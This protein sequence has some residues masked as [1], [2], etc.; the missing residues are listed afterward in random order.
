MWESDLVIISLLLILMAFH[1]CTK[2]QQVRSHTCCWET[3]SH[4]VILIKPQ[5]P[6]EIT[7]W[8]Q[9][10]KTS[11]YSSTVEKTKNATPLKYKGQL[12]SPNGGHWKITQRWQKQRPRNERGKMGRS[13]IHKKKTSLRGMDGLLNQRSWWVKMR[14]RLAAPPCK[15]L[16][17]SCQ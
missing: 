2:Q 9:M 16:W 7:Q 12:P 13:E 3:S 8:D 14:S 17:S 10:N 6:V 11:L 5:K 4:G 15:S 1:F